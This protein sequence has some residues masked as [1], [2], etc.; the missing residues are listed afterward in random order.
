MMR[1]LVSRVEHHGTFSI[2]PCM[3]TIPSAASIA[4]AP[5]RTN[6]NSVCA[7]RTSIVEDGVS[8]FTTVLPGSVTLAT[9]VLGYVGHRD[10]RSLGQETC[11][12]GLAEAVGCTGDDEPPG[13]E[14]MHG[15]SKDASSAPTVARSRTQN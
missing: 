9:I 1:H 15:L 13:I 5:S 6:A 11:R 14:S 3:K 2:R 10:V 7:T 12:D 8:T 4:T